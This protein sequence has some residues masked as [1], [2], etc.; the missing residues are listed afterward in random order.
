MANTQKTTSRKPSPPILVKFHQLYSS[1]SVSL[2]LSASLSLSPW[3]KTQGSVKE[4]LFPE[5]GIINGGVG[6]QSVSA[7]YCR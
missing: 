1:L 3:E 4:S 5:G 2:P 7:P 6:H